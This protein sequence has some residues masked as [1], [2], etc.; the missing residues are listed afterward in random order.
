[1]KIESIYKGII[2]FVL[3]QLMGLIAVLLWPDLALS[4]M[5]GAY[6]S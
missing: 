4:L 6:G 3:L 5:H 2:P 1:M